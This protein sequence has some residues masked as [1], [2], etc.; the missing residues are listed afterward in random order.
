[1]RR[2][3]KHE[4]AFIC[5]LVAAGLFAQ[6]LLANTRL[7][8]L[9]A[10][11]QTNSAGQELLENHFKAFWLIREQHEIVRYLQENTEP[12]ATL[13]AFGLPGQWGRLQLALL[14]DRNIVELEEWTLGRAAPDYIVAHRY[15]NVNADGRAWLN[16]NAD[17]LENIKG[18]EIYK[19]RTAVAPLGFDT[20]IDPQLYRFS[21]PRTLTLSGGREAN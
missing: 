18:Y 8:A 15:S 9:G 5:L 4:A 19:A 20:A 6:T 11:M 14:S 17:L 1:M 10:G 3:G 12:D 7:V 2:T 13:V 16:A 21:L